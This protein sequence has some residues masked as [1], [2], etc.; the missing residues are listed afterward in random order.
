MVRYFHA[1]LFCICTGILFWITCTL[2]SNQAEDP[3]NSTVMFLP[4]GNN[5]VQQGNTKK[6]GMRV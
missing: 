2:P 3:K 5:T 1:L 4:D 6:I